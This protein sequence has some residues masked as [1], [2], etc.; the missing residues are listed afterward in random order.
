MARLGVTRN[1]K[2][3]YSKPQRRRR[4]HSEQL[5]CLRN[6]I[7]KSSKNRGEGSGLPRPRNTNGEVTMSLNPIKQLFVA[8]LRKHSIRET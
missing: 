6:T 4:S 7:R 8:I 3:A 5:I 2:G 1:K